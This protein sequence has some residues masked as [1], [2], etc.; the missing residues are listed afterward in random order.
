MLIQ[1]KSWV[2][3][4]ELKYRIKFNQENSIFTATCF[5]FRADVIIIFDHP[6]YARKSFILLGAT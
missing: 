4:N 2:T 6:F 1:S 3:Y 5:L